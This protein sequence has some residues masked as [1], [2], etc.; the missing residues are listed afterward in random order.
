MLL[1]N[2]HGSTDSYRYGFQGQEKDDEIKGE[3]NSYTTYFRQ[4]NPRLGRAFSLDRIQRAG[5]GMYNMMSN[6]PIVMVDPRGD[7]DY[8]N[9]KGVYLYTDTKTSNDIRIIAQ[10]QF[11]CIQQNFTTQIADSNSSYPNLIETLETQ[12][13]KVTIKVKGS[14]FKS[15]LERSNL[16]SNATST[17]FEKRR[18][19][20]VGVL[21]LDVKK[22]EIRLETAVSENGYVS[23]K[24]NT[25]EKGIL[26][27]MTMN[28]D[29]NPVLS[30]DKNL[31]V[32]ALTHTHPYGGE[33]D[34]VFKGSTMSFDP[35]KPLSGDED[36][37]SSI[38]RGVANYQ[39]WPDYIDKQYRGALSTDNITTTEQLIN[40]NTLNSSN[41]RDRFNIVKD[42]M[43]TFGRNNKR[44]GNNGV[45]GN[46][47]KNN[48]K[49]KAQ[50]LIK[51][52][53]ILVI[54]MF[55][56][57]YSCSKDDNNGDSAKKEE[58]KIIYKTSE[59]SEDFIYNS[60][61]LYSRK[62][63]DDDFMRIN[64]IQWFV[65]YRYVFTGI[66][67]QHLFLIDYCN[68]KEKES[69]IRYKELLK[70][71]NRY[72]KIK[73]TFLSV[74]FESDLQFTNSKR[75]LSNK[76]GNR[77]VFVLDDDGNIVDDGVN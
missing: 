74:V 29:G 52:V 57:L 23:D 41:D 77:L 40:N 48:E 33:N 69:C 46:I 55:L 18:K 5:Q 10:E 62:I 22:A 64:N 51:E 68:V 70:K 45:D 4:F 13:T 43:K 42:A 30:A 16:N 26:P 58:N 9:E 47:K 28:G 2:R 75:H 39:I 76:T 24:D 38:S 59:V 32:I 44:K 3:G 61:N 15:M 35:R 31:I 25:Y 21:V 66:E 67:N 8:Y 65:T 34:P 12:S 71:T 20:Q 36:P 27:S 1:P 49:Q 11:D 63:Y 73:D 7:D 54:L 19:E 6:N 14:Q 72:L 17:A 60:L 53:S 37:G 56:F 50:I